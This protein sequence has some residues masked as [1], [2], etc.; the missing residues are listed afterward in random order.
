MLSYKDDNDK[1]YGATGMAVS[2]VV[3]D[4]DDYLEGIDLDAA[5]GSI[6]ILSPDY[7]FAGHQEMSPR[8]AWNCLLKHFNLAACMAIG[9]VL[10]RS[11]LLHRASPSQDTV[12][13]L[14]KRI[15]EE[16]AD[17]CSLDP[18]E[19]H[20]LF[21]KRYNY[22]TRVFSHPGV[23][24]VAQSFASE[25]EQRRHLSRLEILEALR[26]LATL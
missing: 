2:L 15:A 19:V 11:L 13:E 20:S 22:F 3:M 1:L 9:N 17:A 14:E 16:G 26:T 12:A 18:D 23:Q 7:F 21:V 5:P 24:Q 8:A 6:M 4:G 10:C 25:L